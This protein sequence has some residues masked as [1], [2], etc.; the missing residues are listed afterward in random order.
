MHLI[1]NMLFLWVLLDNIEAVVG[2]FNF[3]LFYI[4][5]GIAA[6]LIHV[7]TNPYS[8]LPMVGASG[9]DLSGYEATW[10]CFPH[11]AFGYGFYFIYQLMYDLIFLGIWIAQQMVAGFGS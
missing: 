11:P 10:L 9:A 5:G 2:T 8:E 3:I 6:A 4:L 1:G 7:L